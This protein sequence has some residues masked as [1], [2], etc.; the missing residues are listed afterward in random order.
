MSGSIL[1][2]IRPAENTRTLPSVAETTTPVAAVRAVTAAAAACRAPKPTGNSTSTLKAARNT[3]AVWI[4]TITADD[5]GAVELGQFD[6]SVVDVQVHE[7][8]VGLLVSFER[9][10]DELPGA[11]KHLQ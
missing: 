5:E 1:S 11:F 9:I 2:T 4:E 3:P 10:G 6:D 7:R 8:P